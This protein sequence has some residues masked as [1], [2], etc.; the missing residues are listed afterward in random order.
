MNDAQGPRRGDKGY[1]AACKRHYRAFW[2]Q[3]I[4]V[5]IIDMEQDLS[6][7]K[8]LI[9]PMLYMIRPG[10]DERVAE[11]VNN[12]GT[13]VITYWSGIVNDNDLVFLGGW[14]GGKLRGVQGIW[15]EEIDALYESDTNTVVPIT[16]NGLGLKG[17]YTA[18]DY[19]DL[20]HPE[21]AQVLATYKSDFYAG[22]AALT[23]NAYGE[24][25]AYTI[26]SN[27]DDRFFGDFYGALAGELS[28][29]RSLDAHLPHGVSA[30]LR[31]DGE[32][33]FI[34]LMNY[35][36]AV[37]GIDLGSSVYTDLLTGET[38]TGV[39]KLGVYGVKVLTK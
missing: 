36:D 25:R 30:Q 4:P 14:P 29:L 31:T 10:V 9:A 19:C 22:R 17:E 27:N 5:D 12:G 28:L 39:V 32:R 11:F 21:S 34:F 7:Y 26:A 24:G 18:R 13:L 15:A 23:V 35:N 16:D 33:P 3:G 2:A 6:G 1:L 38:L 8:L 20:I 37:R